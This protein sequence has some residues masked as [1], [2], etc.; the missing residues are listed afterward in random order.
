MWE[1]F[2]AVELLVRHQTSFKKNF[3]II[4]FGPVSPFFIVTA[5]H[6]LINKVASRVGILVG[7]HDYTTASDTQ[8]SALYRSS[9]FIRH[10][11]YSTAT[12][13]NDIALIKTVEMIQFN[14]GVSPVCLPF[15]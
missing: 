15:R 11:K 5:A 3:L 8:Y 4:N 9:S 7:D 13:Q 6:C 12:K 2:F 10:E 1:R 14:H